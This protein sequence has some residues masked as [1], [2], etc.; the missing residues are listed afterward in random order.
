MPDNWSAA[1][2]SYQALTLEKIRFTVARRLSKYECLRSARMDADDF[3]ARMAD[4][5]L[6]RLEVDI[7]G[8]EVRREVVATRRVPATWR[9]GLRI[10]LAGR[11]GRWAKR[12]PRA[13]EFLGV[14]AAVRR[15][16]GRVRMETIETEVR[17]YRVCPHRDTSAIPGDHYRFLAAETQQA[18]R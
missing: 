11:L 18:G 7:L 5:L 8:R 3:A 15:L 12:H 10:D 4:G 9:D 1:V 17:E 13:G 14:N 16:N 6:I 2:A